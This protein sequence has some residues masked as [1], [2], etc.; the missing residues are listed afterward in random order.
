LTKELEEKNV[1]LYQLR[2]EAGA[3]K[4]ARGDEEKKKIRA[5]AEGK[6]A[7]ARR[8]RDLIERAIERIGR[9]SSD[10]GYPRNYYFARQKIIKFTFLFCSVNYPTKMIN[11]HAI[12]SKKLALSLVELV[13][14][15]VIIGILAVVAIPRV[16][17]FY[18]I[19][20]HARRKN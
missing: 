4:R 18:N 12:R 3:K 11:S 5:D 1:L 7:E 15:M 16:E 8:L 20:F 13:M 17:V 19:K 9:L 14:V 6:D 10:N 2:D